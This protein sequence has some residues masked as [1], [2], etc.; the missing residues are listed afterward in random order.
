MDWHQVIGESLVCLPILQIDNHNRIFEFELQ[1]RQ[2]DELYE[3]YGKDPE[4]QMVDAFL[5]FYPA[6]ICELFERFN[7]SK[8]VLTTGRYD[9][10]RPG[11]VQWKEWND[12]LASIAAGPGSV[13]AANN[14]YDVQYMR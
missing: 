14:Q 3:I 8:I 2:V 6:A 13:I 1:R 5:C 7:Q 9:F 11:K 12:R 4:W 10:Q